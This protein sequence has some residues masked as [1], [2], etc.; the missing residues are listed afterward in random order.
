[1]LLHL[2]NKVI[3]K[4][5]M[6]HTFSKSKILLKS[7]M[8]HYCPLYISDFI[9]TQGLDKKNIFHFRKRQIIFHLFEN[10]HFSF[11]NVGFFLLNNKQHIRQ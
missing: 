2:Q 5:M 6:Q 8:H 3:L 9:F 1:M 11:T 4:T 7:H 10:Q